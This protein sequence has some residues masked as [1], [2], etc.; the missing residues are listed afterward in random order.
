MIPSGAKGFSTDKISHSSLQ[1]QEKLAFA[2][3][4]ID[5]QQALLSTQSYNIHPLAEVSSLAAKNIESLSPISI[6]SMPNCFLPKKIFLIYQQA[7][8]NIFHFMG[9]KKSLPKEKSD[10]CEDTAIRALIEAINSSEIKANK[11]EVLSC[12]MKDVLSKE[13]SVFSLIK[14][15]LKFLIK[16]D[17]VY[18][19]VFSKIEE[20]FLD[21][22]ILTKVDVIFLFSYLVKIVNLFFIK[23]KLEIFEKNTS[24]V[25]EF[26][27]SDYLLTAPFFCELFYIDIE[28]IWCKTIEARL[29]SN[30]YIGF[31][32]KFNSSTL[33]RL[34]VN[35]IYWRNI[36]KD[37][38][39]DE[40][41]MKK[42]MDD[43]SGLN[44]S[45][46]FSSAT[47]LNSIFNR[48]K[49]SELNKEEVINEIKHNNFKL[50]NEFEFYLDSYAENPNK[51]ISTWKNKIKSEFKFKN[52]YI[53]VDEDDDHFK[54]VFYFEEFFYEFFKDSGNT[55]EIIHPPYHVNTDYNIEGESK[56]VYSCI[57]SFIFSV[58]SE[59]NL[60]GQSG[61]KH[62]DIYGSIETDPSLLFRFYID[63]N[64]Q[65]WM[66][67][68]F[69]REDS[70][71]AYF[72]YPAQYRQ[73]LKSK[74]DMLAITITSFNQLLQDGYCYNTIDS[75]EQFYHFSKLINF[76]KHVPINLAHLKSD[77]DYGL[78][79]RHTIELR[80][81]PCARNGKEVELIDKLIIAWVST[82]KKEHLKRQPLANLCLKDPV[83]GYLD[84][85]ELINYYRNFLSR[86]GLDYTL[87]ESLIRS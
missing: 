20:S 62:I 64:N 73:P 51:L 47:L 80:F 31:H 12:L 83:A 8:E 70:A 79:P 21:R 11:A 52:Q 38:N 59:L 42:V 5:S 50:G 14:K 43:F 82:V 60:R 76:D 85:E 6:G 56:S 67:K 29:T 25:L 45:D 39:L 81:L 35:V 16:I 46:I 2:E 65:A 27:I 40:D 53:N 49:F 7:I 9:N 44:L 86:I 10:V 41:G 3:K 68:I 1:Q 74:I 87:Y 54:C 32:S 34:V 84:K 66:P 4:S 78:C 48:N 72:R 57:D 28:N 15:L 55:L 23:N 33:S 77:T 24:I 22:D 71:D 17:S 36:D 26:I 13:D 30:C 18:E 37:F 19:Y 63:V 58:A 75:S 69:N 61:H